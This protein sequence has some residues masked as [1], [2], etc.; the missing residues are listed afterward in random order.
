MKVEFSQLREAIAR[1]KGTAVMKQAQVETYSWFCFRGN[2]V[3]SFDGI[4]GT[5]TNS[6]IELDCCV[7]AKKFWSVV[8]TLSKKSGTITIAPGWLTIT[9][10]SFQTKVPTHDVRDFPELMPTKS[11]P[12]SMASNLTDALKLVRLTMETDEAREVIRGVGLKGSHAMSTDGLRV[13]MA[14]LSEPVAGEFVLGTAMV[15]QLI[16]LGQPTSVFSYENMMGALYKD[17]KTILVSRKPVGNFPFQA[18]TEYLVGK[19]G[20]SFESAKLLEVVERIQGASDND[21]TL[22]LACTPGWLIVSSE[23]GQTKEEIPFVKDTF[24]IKVK[25]RHLQAAL[26]GYKPW[27]IRVDKKMIE[28][29]S[30]G[31]NHGIALMV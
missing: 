27:S 2:K 15:R 21:V 23:D 26:K 25:A 29:V 1:V 5:I 28:L 9:A 20:H 31:V 4:S 30:A 22:S 17:T 19:H 14:T 18:I 7:P 13:T 12:V 6:G 24:E 3:S 10:G 16:R 8:D 11:Q